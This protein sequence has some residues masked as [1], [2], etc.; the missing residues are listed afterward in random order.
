M[1]EI[2]ERTPQ[3]RVLLPSV[4]QSDTVDAVHVSYSGHIQGPTQ[5]AWR[6]LLLQHGTCH[7]LRADVTGRSYQGMHEALAGG[8]AKRTGHERSQNH[9]GQG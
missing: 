5:N 4:L 9:V 2:S 1:G 8:L 3:E 6:I 7:V